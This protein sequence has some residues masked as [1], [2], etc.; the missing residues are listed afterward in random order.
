MFVWCPALLTSFFL[1]LEIQDELNKVKDDISKSMS[2]LQVDKEYVKVL[3]SQ[4]LSPAA[5]LEKL[6]EYSCL[7]MVLGAR[8]LPSSLTW[9]GGPLCLRGLRAVPPWNL[10][11]QEGPTP[12]SRRWL[13]YFRNCT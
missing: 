2:F 7:G 12:V 5:V 3:P 11:A 10:Y 8:V 1:P 9:E 6:K 13:L 4:G